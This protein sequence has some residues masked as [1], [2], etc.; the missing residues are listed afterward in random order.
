MLKCKFQER[1]SKIKKSKGIDTK[2]IYR[3]ED[4]LS[5]V[6]YELEAGKRIFRSRA[7]AFDFSHR[8]VEA[9]GNRVKTV[10]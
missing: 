8:K 6:V 9:A 10:V 7:E 3:R 4:D 1:K 2:K 5:S